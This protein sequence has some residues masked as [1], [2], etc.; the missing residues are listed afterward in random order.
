VAAYRQY[1]Q[2]KVNSK[3]SVFTWRKAP[4]RKPAWIS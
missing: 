1:M 2:F 3:P 4:H